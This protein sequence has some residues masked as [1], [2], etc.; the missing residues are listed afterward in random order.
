MTHPIDDSDPETVVDDKLFLVLQVRHGWQT[1]KPVPVDPDTRS[2]DREFRWIHPDPEVDDI[3][4]IARY[5]DGL[6]P[7]VAPRMVKTPAL[8]VE[9]EGALAAA[10]GLLAPTGTVVFNID[11]EI[12]NRFRSRHVTSGAVAKVLDIDR[13]AA[14]RLMKR[15]EK[16]G[17]VTRIELDWRHPAT[18][19]PGA[20]NREKTG[21]VPTAV[22]DAF[23]AW[24][25]TP[26][27]TLA[28]RSAPRVAEAFAANQARYPN[29]PREHPMSGNDRELDAA[30]QLGLITH[31][32]DGWVPAEHAEA[33]K[34]AVDAYIAAVEARDAAE[35][36]QKDRVQAGLDAWTAEHR[37][38]RTGRYL[39]VSANVLEQ[40]L[41]AAGH[42]TA[43]RIETVS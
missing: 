24:E 1:Q 11:G 4:V 18:M 26:I 32:H 2:G 23:T 21:W 33:T 13:A 28:A 7:I 27:E 42:D 43:D 37:V 5:E 39:N 40:L 16:A 35:A 19:W 9:V 36:A 8:P 38:A 34:A 41:A 15:A 10:V 6:Y 30:A 12:V 20:S 17:D 22:T 29:D 14:D 25:N 31:V 3:T